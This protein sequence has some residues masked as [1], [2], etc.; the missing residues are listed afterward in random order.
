M[1]VSI[2]THRPHRL[3]SGRPVVIE[4]ATGRV[5]ATEAETLMDCPWTVLVPSRNPEPD[6]EA[7]CWNQVPCSAAAL[8]IE[9]EGWLCA[10]SHRHLTYG[11]PAQIVEERAEA[12]AE[13]NGRD[14]R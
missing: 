7:D 8:Y 2:F 13:M 14:Y 1:T 10:S 5:V 9:A 3:A 4:D 6:S 12:L 11:S